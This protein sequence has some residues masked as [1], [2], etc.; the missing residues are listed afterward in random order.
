M[1]KEP[2]SNGTVQP[3]LVGWDVGGWNCDHN[4]NSRD[5]LAVLGPDLALLGK[6]WRGNL[7]ERIN[8]AKDSEEFINALLKLC[9]VGALPVETP[10]VLA[11][12]APLGFST[13]FTALLNGLQPAEPPG[14]SATNP[15]LYRQTERLL[16]EWG[17]SPLSA[18]KDM[19]GSQTTKAMHVLA[20][21]APH[22]RS[23]GIW[24]DDKRLTVLE[25]YPSACKR[26]L[27]IKDL[28]SQVG[29]VPADHPD[30]EDAITCALVAHLF[31]NEPE[32]L[33]RPT[34]DISAR[35]GWIWFPKD[36]LE[37]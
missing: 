25:A 23:C 15:Y 17:L 37:R 8:Q 18:V 31:V 13:E 9:G 34:P 22:I 28:R 30:K 5:A 2:I 27:L 20:R 7:R 11:I 3:Y 36:G 1:Q 33:V 35:E 6:T 19:L 32:Q 10:V 29:A 24:E 12:D 16:F 4:A 14:E 26:S 21:F